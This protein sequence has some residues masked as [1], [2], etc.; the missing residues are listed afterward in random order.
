VSSGGVVIIPT[1]TVYGFSCDPGNEEAVRRIYE[2]KRREDKPFIILD[3]SI[4]RIVSRYFKKDPFTEM[5]IN[6]FIKENLWPGNITLIADKNNDLNFSFLKNIKKIAVRYTT[7]EIISR[8][9]GKIDSGII[10]TSINIS[11]EKFLNDISEIN[12]VWSDKVDFIMNSETAGNSSSSI[13]ELISENKC[14]KFIRIS[15]QV[16]EKEIETKISGT[17]KI[18]R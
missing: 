16:L 9:C 15:D 18:C 6:E 13:I 2:L 7:N 11:G 4:D 12:S 5:M 17:V 14:V 8:I 3:S 1:D 10:S